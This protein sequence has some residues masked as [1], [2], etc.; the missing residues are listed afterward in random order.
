MERLQKVIANSGF[1]SRRKAEEYISRGKVFVNG[2]KVTE[3]GTKVNYEDEIIVDGQV[4]NS[5]EDKE[6]YLLY[7][8]E[9]V[10]SSVSDEKG[11]RTVIDLVPTKTRIYPIGRLDYNTTGL[12]LLTN[13]GDLANKLMH[14][15]HEVEKIYLAKIN[16]ILSPQ[17]YM[18]LKK[19]LVVEGR[20]VV[21]TYLKVKKV[22]K[23]ANTSSILIGIVEGRNHIVKNIMET[24][25]HE[26]LRLKRESY[27]F[28]N[29]GGLK[30]GECRKLS[31]KEVKTLYS[32]K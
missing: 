30:P 12:L 16:G 8:P 13:D 6:Y 4:L 21:P 20:K 14:P 15:S 25:G 1:C 28:L 22:N 2:E 18:R 9:G 31:V 17:E 32:L 27:A 29:L 10:I 3:L 24:L 5:K 11:R 26:V 19:G 7:K 23:D